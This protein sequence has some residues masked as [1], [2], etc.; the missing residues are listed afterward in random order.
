[1]EN[2]CITLGYKMH[3]KLRRNI[4]MKYM[5]SDNKVVVNKSEKALHKQRVEKVEG[6]DFIKFI[7]L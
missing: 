7:Y 6:T 1:M 3:H 2:F 4:K 5:W